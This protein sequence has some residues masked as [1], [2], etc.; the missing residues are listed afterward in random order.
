[1]TFEFEEE[2]KKK[3][4]KRQLTSDEDI[5]SSGW[6]ERDQRMWF[7]RNRTIVRVSI[8]ANRLHTVFANRR[9]SFLTGSVVEGFR[10]SESRCSSCA[11]FR[12]TFLK[13]KKRDKKTMKQPKASIIVA[14]KFVIIN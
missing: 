7:R 5:S 9:G 8:E 4:K 6:D 3:R 1:M 2:E 13:I 12:I 14:G 10:T 11:K